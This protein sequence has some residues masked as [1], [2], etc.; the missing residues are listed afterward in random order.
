[1]TPFFSGKVYNILVIIKVVYV[2]KGY[3]LLFI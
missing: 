1:M 3:M 2:H